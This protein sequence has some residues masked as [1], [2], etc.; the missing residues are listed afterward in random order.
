MNIHFAGR[1][2]G[3]FVK[4]LPVDIFV[5]M[6]LETKKG[7]SWNTDDSIVV[8]QYLCTF[9]PGCCTKSK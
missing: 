3:R 8:I 5:N 1:D 2:Y 9:I 7:R 4:R 6:T